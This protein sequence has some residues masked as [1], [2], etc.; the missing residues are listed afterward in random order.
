[1]K[2]KRIFGFSAIIALFLF[3][4]FSSATLAQKTI[5]FTGKWALNESKSEL[6]EGRFF[7]AS[8][9]N[10]KQDGNTMVID[11]VR[12]GRD[13]GTRT[14]TENLTLDG[15][16]SVTESEF[17]TMTSTAVWSEDGKSLTIKSKS[18]FEREGQTFTMNM[19]EIWT[20]EEEGKLLKIQSTSSS[21]RGE[22]SVTL[23]YDKK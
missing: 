13:G 16:E 5:D 12:T 20:L 6:G 11:R 22:R 15:K 9:L 19:T 3:V 17:R 14:T 1:M 18:E 7:S 2:Q 4:C 23:A 8:E 10:V 21:P